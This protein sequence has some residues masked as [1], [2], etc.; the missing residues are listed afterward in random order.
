MGAAG[1]MKGGPRSPRRR[2]LVPPLAW[3]VL[4]GG[5]VLAL[6]GSWSH[7]FGVLLGPFAGAVARDWQDGCA[8]SSWAIAPSAIAGL[9][10]G[11]ATQP[12]L[13]PKGGWLALCRSAV[14]WLCSFSRFWAARVSCRHA[15]E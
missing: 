6:T 10:I 4:S 9:A 12:R 7:A 13:R 1:P 3:F 2:F 14:R 15:L 8:E 5:L 11:P